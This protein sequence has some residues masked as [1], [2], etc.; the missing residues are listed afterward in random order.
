[1]LHAGLV[2]CAGCVTLDSTVIPCSIGPVPRWRG[3]RDRPWYLAVSRRL[4]PDGM[5]LRQERVTHCDFFPISTDFRVLS[6]VAYD[7]SLAIVVA[8][9]LYGKRVIA[10]GEL[11]AIAV[12]EPSP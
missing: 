2:N 6:G 9:R 5:T 1:M 11:I 3:R 8:S 4:P 10:R 7:S 12:T